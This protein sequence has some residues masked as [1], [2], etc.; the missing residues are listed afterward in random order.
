MIQATELQPPIV[1]PVTE[2]ERRGSSR[3]E[4]SLP[5]S[6]RYCPPKRGSTSFSGETVNLSGHG[7]YLVT[8]TQFAPDTRLALMITLPGKKPWPAAFVARARVRV[9]RCQ[10]IWHRAARRVGVGAEIEYYRV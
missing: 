6:I 7:I 1:Q 9:V 3:F 10:P 4:I 2:G 8:D 5:L